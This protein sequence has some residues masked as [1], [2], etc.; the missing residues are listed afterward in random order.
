MRRKIGVV[1]GVLGVLAL[2]FGVVWMTVV[3]PS[4][5][6]VPAD[7]EQ[8][9]DLQGTVTLYDEAH[10]GEVTM[11]V[12]GHRKYTA[13]SAT[14]DVLYMRE[15]LWFDIAGTDQEIGAL[16]QKFLL[17]TDRVERTNLEGLGDGVG[18][19]HY[20]F[21]FDVKKDKVYP[22]WNEGNPVNLDCVYVDEKDYE[23][24]HVYVFEMSTPEG[25]LSLPASFD[26]PAMRIDQ[27]ITL[28]CEP[29]SGMPV[30]MEDHTKRSGQIPVPD[31]DFPSTAPFTYENVTFYQDDLVFTDDTVAGLV[32]DANA[33][34]TQV[35]LAKNLLPWLSI[36]SGILLV[37]VGVFLAMKPG[38]AAAAPP[39]PQAAAPPPEQQK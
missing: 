33:A 16:R 25:G 34:K 36:G 27:T 21:P 3:W 8:Q 23:G 11:D 6:K 7:L 39:K 17:G 18:G 32:D 5:A 22:W 4:L 9:V 30:Y 15:D 13:L 19:G 35:A 14:D 10:G 37:L 26:T 1:L 20:S 29:T 38:K 24:L 31:K 28:Y 12:S 2:V